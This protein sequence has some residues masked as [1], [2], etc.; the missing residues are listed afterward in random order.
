MS[1]T[2]VS[3]PRTIPPHSGPPLIGHTLRTRRDP[4][5]FGRQMYQRYGP[6]A[7]VSFLGR[8]MVALYGPEAVGT[9]LQNRDRAFASGPAWS[10]FI[11]PFFR[12]GVM[13]LDFDEHQH[14]RRILQQAFTAERLS[15]YLA[16]MNPMIGTALDRWRP[17]PGFHFY[18]AVKQLTLDLATATFMGGSL[19]PEAD[20]IN[21]AF[22]ACVRA[23]TSLIRI[24]VPGL[25]WSRG[26]AARRTLEEFLHSQLPARRAGAT[27]DD[28]LGALCETQSEDGQRFTDEDV[29]NHMIFLLMAAHDTS[30]ITLTTMAYHLARHPEWQE[31]CRRESAAL[32]TDTLD[33][34]DLDR[35]PSLDLV[36]RESLRLVPPVPA[37]PRLAV[38]D[39]QIAGFAVPKGSFVVASILT[40]HH[41]A[42]FWPDPDTFDPERFAGHRREDRP[43]RHAWEP[44]GGGVHKCIGMYFAGMEIKAVL[45]Q[46]LLRHRWSVDPAY[47]MPLDWRALPVPRDG[48]PVRL[49]RN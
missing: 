47:R 17:D 24:P 20:R 26:L 29:V 31:R 1:G 34:A 27:G 12:R 33:Y 46:L 48:L 49:D 16:R 30:T 23:G 21:R 7:P 37:L 22:V 11:G 18:S 32:G 19:G 38:A 10:F 15:G 45:H 9:A 5:G 43:H 8:P 25:P 41:L 40:T 3:G 2:D 35:L 42:D 39:T 28:L 14:H 13:L 6:V 44:F 4:I 36:M